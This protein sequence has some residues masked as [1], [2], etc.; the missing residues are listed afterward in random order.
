MKITDYPIKDEASGTTYNRLKKIEASNGEFIF[1]GS[2]TKAYANLMDFID[3][4]II[5]YT[6]RGN[7]Y[8]RDCAGRRYMIKELEIWE[9]IKAETT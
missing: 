8:K 6:F 2:N 4:Q 5:F 9:R 7:D 3:K 1:V